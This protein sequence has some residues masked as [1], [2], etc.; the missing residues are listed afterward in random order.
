MALRRPTKEITLTDITVIDGGTFDST[1]LTVDSTNDRVGVGTAS[2]GA[3]LDVQDATTSSA[4]TG[5]K[6][7]LSADDGAPMGDS[8]RLGV[9]EFTGAEDSSGTQVVG[10]RIEALTDA[11]WTN[12]ENG[13]ALYFYTTDGNA[14]QT[15]V[16]KLDSNQKATFSGLIQGTTATL[17]GLATFNGNATVLSGS[18]SA[19]SKVT[20]GT[21]TAKTTIGCP[22][23][24]DTFFTGTAAGD[25]VLRAD[26]NNNKVHVGAGTSGKAAMVVTE[27]ANVGK[28]GVGTANPGAQ[29]DIQDTTTS[30]ASTGGHLRLSADDGAAMDDSH[31]LGVI[32]FT[33]AEDTGGSQTVGARIE[34]LTDAAWSASENGCALYFYTTDGNASQSNVLKIDSNKKSTFNG[35]LD[36]T[37]T[38]DSS[39]D[40]GDTGALRC[41]GG[42]SIA[43]KLYVGTDLTVSG[44][45]ITFGNA[46]AAKLSITATD[47]DTAG[48]EIKF[49][50]GA[51]TAGTTDDIA[52]GSLILEGGQGK[53]TGVGG[54]IEFR[55]AKAAGGSASSLNSL[56]TVMKIKQSKSV[57]IQ[58]PIVVGA[59][60][61]GHD[62]KFYGATPS[63]YMLWDEGEDDLILGGAAGIVVPEG[64]LILGSTAISATAAELNILDASAAVAASSNQD[65]SN[66]NVTSNNFKISHTLTLNGDLANDSG[67]TV[68]TVTSDK[69]LA[70]SVVIASS[71]LLDM[72]APRE[73]VAGSFK[74]SGK[75]KTG[76]TLLDDSTVV[77][78][79]II[80]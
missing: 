2:P 7:R 58:G 36:I 21:D 61:S 45:D 42:A 33:G 56:S 79:Y 29:L 74:V 53:G 62:V 46:Q 27:V 30:G 47:H 65:S 37:D 10:A 44:G 54:D 55:V 57:D 64:Q 3:K 68:F 49:S 40:S 17:S 13:C 67:I 23:G 8:H 24:T 59:D 41:E 26:D 22:G 71:N 75:N 19:L 39:D 50:A 6:L 52:G 76:G 25:L 80:L 11:A 60:D 69:V 14:S 9:L 12:V 70:T 78:N 15:N 28:V 32:E 18:A 51:P 43:K 35:V 38:T 31:R 72:S 63:A 20:L 4:N 73:V 34:A 16:L 48:E 5:G 77:I 1:T 66:G